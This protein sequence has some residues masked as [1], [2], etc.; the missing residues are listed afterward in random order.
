MRTFTN[1]YQRPKVEYPHDVH[2]HTPLEDYDYNFMY[3]VKTLSSDRVEV[4]PFLVSL[5]APINHTSVN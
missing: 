1:S 4:R 2:L 3:D 5:E